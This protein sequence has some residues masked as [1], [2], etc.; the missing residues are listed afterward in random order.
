MFSL[1]ALEP[2]VQA[3]SARTAKMQRKSSKIMKNH[4]KTLDMYSKTIFMTIIHH[5]KH[6][7]ARFRRFWRWPSHVTTSAVWRQ[8]PRPPRTGNGGS[9]H[10]SG[11]SATQR[12][13]RDCRP[14]TQSL[15]SSTVH[16]HVARAVPGLVPVS[17][18]AAPRIGP[19]W[20]LSTSDTLGRAKSLSGKA[21]RVIFQLISIYRKFSRYR[22]DVSKNQKDISKNPQRCIE[23]SNF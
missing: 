6:S 8:L 20:I 17:V 23:F 1:Y 2:E 13:V 9:P 10:S 16:S 3:V 7:G 14:Q 19:V 5:N 12:V 18:R 11:V 15:H 4:S 22:K 21:N